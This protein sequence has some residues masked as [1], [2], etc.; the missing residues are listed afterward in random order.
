MIALSDAAW[1]SIGT[2]V[3][4][5]ATLIA[6]LVGNRRGTVIEKKTEAVRNSVTTPAED[7]RTVGEILSEAHPEG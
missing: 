3:A 7:G 5:C 1:T 4:S 6:V 2:I